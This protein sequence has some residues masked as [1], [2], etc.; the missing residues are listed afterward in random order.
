MKAT[1]NVVD[2]ASSMDDDHVIIDGKRIE[3][4]SFKG[5]VLTL[6]DGSIFVINNE[7]IVAG[8]YPS[9]DGAYSLAPANQPQVLVPEVI[10]EPENLSSSFFDLP[11]AFRVEGRGC[12]EH[13]GPDKPGR[14]HPGYGPDLGVSE[15]IQLEGTGFVLVGRVIRHS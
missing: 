12:I 5:D 3:I 11:G 6:E 2:R 4:A 7:E 1:L 9:T 15:P 10:Y 8:H 13:N 14:Y